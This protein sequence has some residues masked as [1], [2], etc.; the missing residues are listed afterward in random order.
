MPVI[1]RVDGRAFHTV[2]RS[3]QK[4]FDPIVVSAMQ[5][6]AKSLCNEIQNAKLAY[7]QSDEISI[8]LNNYEKLETQSWFGNNIQKMVSISAA[9]AT[10]EWHFNPA[11][12]PRST[13]ESPQA[14][15][16]SRI[17]VLPKEATTRRYS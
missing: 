10:R 14:T 8:L 2:L 11:L 9:V 15:F 7:I 12:N 17:F 13:Y 3:A 5:R 1:V 6:V 16:D 4:P